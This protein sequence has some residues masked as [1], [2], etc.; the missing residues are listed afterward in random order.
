[1]ISLPARTESIMLRLAT[2]VDAPTVRRLAALDD[3]PRLTGAVLLALVDGEPVAALSLADGRVVADPFRL[4]AHE[5]T[6]LR[7]H[8]QHLTRPARERSKGGL[9]RRRA[10]HRLNLRVAT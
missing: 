6:L 8:A 4:T 9:R 10:P 2:D 5:V 3:A 1:M 7:L